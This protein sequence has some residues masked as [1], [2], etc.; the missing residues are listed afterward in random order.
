MRKTLVLGSKDLVQASLPIQATLITLHSQ[1]GI[2][3]ND[4]NICS[5]KSQDLPPLSLILTFLIKLINQL[6]CNPHLTADHLRSKPHMEWRNSYPNPG[7]W[8]RPIS[9]DGVVLSLVGTS[10]IEGRGKWEKNK[11][12]E[13]NDKLLVWAVDVLMGF[14]W[15]ELLQ[16]WARSTLVT[17]GECFL[18]FFFF[19]FSFEVFFYMAC[20]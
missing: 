16:N 13:R 14:L 8:L 20:P 7:I 17:V 15:E 5:L 19:L 3:A 4:I 11:G 9:P 1:L 18:F 12:R 10:G 6:N 2:I